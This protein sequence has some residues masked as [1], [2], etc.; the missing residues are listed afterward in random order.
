MLREH[1]IQFG[2]LGSV[3][4][5][6]LCVI[7]IIRVS[8]PVIFQYFRHVNRLPGLLFRFCQQFYPNA[9]SHS[10]HAGFIEGSADEKDFVADLEIEVRTCIS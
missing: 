1:G 2:N 4:E 8:K 7:R 9:V 3:H 10:G 6:A 5:K